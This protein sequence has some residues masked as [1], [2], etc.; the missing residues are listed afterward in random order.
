[1]SS[2]Y[3]PPDGPPSGVPGGKTSL[4]LESNVAAMLCYIGNLVCCLGVVLSIVV[5]IT[6]KENRF[7]KFHAV[8][9]LFVAI[10]GIAMAILVGLLGLVLS[11]LLRDLAF[12]GWF[13]ALPAIFLIVLWIAVAIAF[14]VGGLILGIL[15]GVAVE[16]AG[17]GGGVVCLLFTLIYLLVCLVV[18]LAILVALILAAVKAYGGNWFKL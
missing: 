16:A 4:G 15:C 10:A 3:E 18:P 14:V 2:V 7:V 11:I 8:Q 12:V 9:S 1:M 5:L 6:E 13:R 17:S